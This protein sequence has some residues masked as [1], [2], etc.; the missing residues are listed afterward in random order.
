MVAVC[1]VCVCLC[2]RLGVCVCVVWGS[3]AWGLVYRSCANG[4]MVFMLTPVCVRVCVW[5]VTGREVPITVRQ[6]LKAMQA[7]G[8]VNTVPVILGSCK[9]N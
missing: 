9:V 3:V 7:N 1:R 6:P 5:L 2:V 4:Y 8:F